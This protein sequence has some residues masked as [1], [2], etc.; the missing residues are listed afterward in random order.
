MKTIS[1]PI[2]VYSAG[3][4][5]RDVRSDCRVTIELRSEGDLQIKLN[6]KVADYYG[7][8]IRDQAAREL[9]RCGVRN[10]AV[11]IED[12]A[13][14]P[15]VI[16][17]RIEAAARRAGLTSIEPPPPRI[18]SRSESPKDR[19][20]RSR[21]YVPGCE[22]KYFVN[23][24]LYRPDA[25]ILD[26][27]DAVHPDEKDSARLLVRNALTQVSFA[28]PGHE[29][30]ECERMVRI[31]PF[32]MGLEDLREVVPAQP[33]LIL[34]PKAET[35][36]QVV[37]VEH[38]IEEIQSANGSGRNIWLMPIIETALGVENAY[39]IASA[40]PKVCSIAIG[41]EDYTADLGVVKTESGT[42]SFYARTRLVNA[43]HAARVQASDS[44]FGNVS[45]MDALKR[46]AAGSRTMGF[47]GMGCVHPRQVDVIHSAFAPAPQELEKALLIVEAFE[48]AK[49]QGL[50]VVSLRSKMIDKPVVIRAL[51]MI[52]NARK[53]GM[54]SDESDTAIPLA[55]NDKAVS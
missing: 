49:Q 32:P 42:E 37:E 34:I 25:V 46:W 11:L 24:A 20:R 43:A 52:D 18:P 16:A 13:A 35:A 48:K 40:T 55:G 22:P 5:G 8:S 21:L 53:L 26:L 51:K 7:D 9:K 33:D 4:F 36:E 39:L 27:E 15:F 17:A 23:A 29:S 12:A 47:E 28:P 30:A 10:A 45:D 2:D 1:N 14:L 19:L 38:A 44:V 31:N 41:L 3:S 6:S 50:G 54:L